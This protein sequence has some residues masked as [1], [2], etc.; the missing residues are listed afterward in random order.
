MPA[1]GA[2]LAFVPAGVVVRC[3]G[4]RCNDLAGNLRHRAAQPRYAGDASGAGLDLESF[5]ADRRRADRRYRRT[6]GGV[7]GRAD[8]RRHRPQSAR[9][10]FPGCDPVLHGR[11]VRDGYQHQPGGPHTRRTGGVLAVADLGVHA[12]SGAKRCSSAGIA[13]EGRARC[14][15]RRSAYAP[16]QDPDRATATGSVHR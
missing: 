1:G 13:G 2:C 7:G 5:R 10:D 6:A 12:Y 16:A 14:R 3:R 8:D 4:N 11:V 9:A 15:R